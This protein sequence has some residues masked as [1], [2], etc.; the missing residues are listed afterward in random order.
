LDIRKEDMTEDTINNEYSTDT[1]TENAKSS[2][3]DNHEHNTG[4]ADLAHELTRILSEGVAKAK[5]A[6]D[7][8][9]GIDGI[10]QNTV[11][12]AAEFGANAK[13]VSENIAESDAFKNAV[14]AVRVWA[15]KMAETDAVK[16]LQNKAFALKDVAVSSYVDTYESKKR[17]SETEQKDGTSTE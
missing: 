10:S 9:G 3:S 14:E 8:A 7:N 5:V 4:K 12:K 15:S 13:V 11:K 1:S 16:N 17:N 2:T 6:Y